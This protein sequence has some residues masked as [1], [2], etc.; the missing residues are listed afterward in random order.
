MRYK[1]S[2]VL[3]TVICFCALM[4]A[5]LY[6]AD[7]K[8]PRTYFKLN[9]AP[10]Y[11]IPMEHGPIGGINK[12]SAQMM[13][14]GYVPTT[15]PGQQAGL[16]T[17]DYQHNGSMG[18]HLAFNPVNNMVNFVWMAQS[19]YVIPGNR[20]IR[21]QAYNAIGSP[22][23][24]EQE[25]SGKLITT[26]YS[27]YVSLDATSTGKAFFA[28]H[29]DPF[30][31]DDSHY[32]TTVYEDFMPG[33]GIFSNLKLYP[34][35]TS[36]WYF[37]DANDEALEVIWP[38]IEVHYGTEEVVYAL[39]H[40]F[41]GSEDM[42]L[43]RK[44]DVST[45]WDNGRF[46]A[47][48]TNLAYLIVANQGTDS[49]AIIYADDRFGLDEGEGGNQDCDVYYMLSENQ[50][51]TWS[52]PINISNYTEDS[53]WRVES[54]L[55]AV[56]SDEGTLHVLWAA[57]ELRSATVFENWKSRLIHWDT[58]HGP[59]IISEARYDMGNKCDPDAWNMYIAK[60]SISTCEGNVYA[61]WTQFGEAGNSQAMLDCS[62]GG[63]ANGELYLCGS[64][65]NGLTW[66][67]PNNL[68]NSR[69]LNCDS[70]LCDS[71][72]WSSMARFG[73]VYADTVDGVVPDTLDI[74]YINDKDAGGIPQGSG[75]WTVN[76]V[77]HLRIACRVVDH[78]P[79]TSYEPVAFVDPIHAAPGIKLDTTLRISNIGNDP[80]VWTATIEHVDGDDWMTMASY[81]GTIQPAPATNYADVGVSFNYKNLLVGDPTGWDAYIIV[82]SGA[83][84]SPD[85]LPIHFTVA[86]DFSL[87]K[88]DTLAAYASGTRMTDGKALMIYNTA[89]LGNDQD[90]LCLDVPFADGECD[91]FDLTPITPVWLFSGSPMITWNDGT[92]KAYTSVFTQLFTED[93][94]FRPQDDG[95]EWIDSLPLIGIDVNKCRFRVSTSDSIFGVQVAMSMPTD[96]TND[97]V[98]GRNRFMLWDAIDTVYD[99]NVGMIVD[100]DIPS[101]SSVDNFSYILDTV[102]TDAP[103]DDGDTIR[104][105]T[106]RVF[107]V[108][109]KGAEY[110]SDNDTVGCSVLETDRYGGIAIFNLPDDSL[111]TDLIAW[112]KENTPNQLGSGYDPD[113]LFKYMRGVMDIYSTDSAIDLH[114]G[115]NFD[116]LD[117]IIPGATGVYTY[118]YGLVTTLDGLD[119]FIEQVKTSFAFAKFNE[120][121]VRPGDANLDNSVNVGDAVWMI[122]Y[123]FKGGAAPGN[124]DHGDA[125]NDG[126]LNVGD[127]VYL[128]NY[129]FKSGA[130]P[131]CGHVNDAD[132]MWK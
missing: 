97:F 2:V 72:H 111:P 108:Y 107:V 62:Q 120:Y 58:E 26:E 89:M 30:G 110:H 8:N 127:A 61:L 45:A 104:H 12:E 10:K 86:S 115:I 4:T 41:Q 15:S 40:V 23:D 68:T 55:A 32:Y 109:Q 126:A 106:G 75:S 94:T 101:D 3:L 114:T 5:S 98:V 7:S 130:A 34:D 1:R 128:I 46:M 125:N 76:P 90:Y 31:G 132:L 123:V 56:Y 27:G 95:M 54:D 49:V 119:D 44:P 99:V 53:L 18:R 65:D 67:L 51:D 118:S 66:D 57:R 113:S 122:N 39:S 37:E 83:P 69:T 73:M 43:Y 96:G 79:K 92:N 48:V 78:M 28:C 93:G 103:W 105:A 24:Y 50:G 42:I 9:R 38:Q 29:T 102:F 71:D 14:L 20:H 131:V 22:P 100:W 19:D 124:L 112:T 121:C 25:A 74:L 77:M 60:P 87:P 36:D 116:D 91:T 70:N 63:F 47:K 35:S 85:T 16:T 81:G 82:T 52:A 59:S 84:T 11:A 117:T 17:Y 21:F 64:D 13:S 33:Q 6:G 129:V 80:L 88:G